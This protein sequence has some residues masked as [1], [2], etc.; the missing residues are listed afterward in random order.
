MLR[1]RIRQS[2]APEV[3][4]HDCITRLTTMVDAERRETRLSAIV[5][6]IEIY[7]ESSR[8]LTKTGDLISVAL[9]VEEVAMEQEL[10]ADLIA[11]YL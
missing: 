9:R 11:K 2:I 6:F 4:E 8:A 5:I 3:A 7:E 1:A 10:L